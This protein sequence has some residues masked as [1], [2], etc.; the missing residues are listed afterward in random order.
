MS[1]AKKVNC[2]YFDKHLSCNF[3]PKERFLFFVKRKPICR[4]LE[5][6]PTFT[7][8]YQ[9]LYSKPTL[10]PPPPSPPPPRSPK[11]KLA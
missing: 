5:V 9:E 1:V 4:L 6:R 10:P 3:L 8:E 7:C 11:G 2:Q